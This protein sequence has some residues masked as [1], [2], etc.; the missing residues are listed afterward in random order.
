M[1][2]ELRGCAGPAC[3]CFSG[4]A[5]YGL[6]FGFS[7]LASSA[8]CLGSSLFL[9]SLTRRRPLSKGLSLEYSEA[10]PQPGGQESLVFPRPGIPT[11]MPLCL[12]VLSVSLFQCLSQALSMGMSLGGPANRSTS[13][14]LPLLHCSPGPCRRTLPTCVHLP[15]Q[16]LRPI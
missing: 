8:G 1:A 9:L 14:K 2:G 4:F 6:L 11:G 16:S 13:T 15:D 10:L 7:W 3:Q 12:L 5:C